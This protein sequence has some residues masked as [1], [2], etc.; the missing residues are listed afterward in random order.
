MAS[1]V[2]TLDLRVIDRLLEMG[3]GYVLDFT[4]RT[5]ADFFREHGVDIDDQRFSIEGTSKA[6]RLRYFLKNTP[7]PLTGVILAAL[8]QHRLAWKPDGI[9]DADLDEYR[10]LVVRLGGEL[11]RSSVTKASAAEETMEAKLLRLVF[12]PELFERLPVDLAMSRLLVERMNE[13][14]RCIEVGAYLAAVIV[15]GSVLEGMCL[16]FGSRHSEHLNRGY[17]AVY[18][19][20][21]KKFHEWKLKEWIDVLAF[22][23]YLSP[24]IQKFGHAVRDFRNYIH[25][26]EQLASSFYPDQHTARI[27]FQVVVAAA[28]D[29][30][31]AEETARKGATHSHK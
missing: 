31:R 7:P 22:F 12:K 3:S 14:K 24:N 9:S 11:P 20:S 1:G 10:R 27:C 16:G 30:V 13:A 29:L 4:D 6:K 23:G 2:T 5:F 18:N 19:R 8:L 25:P 15:C 21:P 28:E 17:A 26:G